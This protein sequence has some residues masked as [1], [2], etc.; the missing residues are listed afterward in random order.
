MTIIFLFGNSEHLTYPRVERLEETDKNYKLSIKG[1]PNT[2]F[3]FDKKG[4]T[5]IEVKL[6][7]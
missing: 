3:Y 2:P 1:Q 6:N 5:G 4:I 7:D